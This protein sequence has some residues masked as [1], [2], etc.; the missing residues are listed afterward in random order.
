MLFP[1][2]GNGQTLQTEQNWLTAVRCPA[3]QKELLCPPCVCAF[4]AIM[5]TVVAV[6]FPP[7]VVLLYVPIYGICSP[8]WD[9]SLLWVRIGPSPFKMACA[10]VSGPGVAFGCI[11][12]QRGPAG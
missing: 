1:A 6:P 12:V 3:C 2:F 11:S 7:L 9:L 8:C 4:P 10:A 5:N